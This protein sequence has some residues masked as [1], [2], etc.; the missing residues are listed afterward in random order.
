VHNYLIISKVQFFK[1]RTLKQSI[2]SAAIISW[3]RK[4]QKSKKEKRKKK[5]E[6]RKRKQKDER[7]L[8]R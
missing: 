1:E 3:E 7:A 5:K 2:Q 4:K 8:L 6:K